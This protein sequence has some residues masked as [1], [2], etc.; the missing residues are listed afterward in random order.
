[1]ANY[2]VHHTKKKQILARE[3]AKLRRLIKADASSDQLTAAAERIREARIRVLRVQRAMVAP[4]DDAD[5]VYERIDRAIERLAEKTT[6]SIV[7]EFR[8]GFK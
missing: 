1:M 5:I 6:D 3:E 7:A 8:F 2:L 4:K